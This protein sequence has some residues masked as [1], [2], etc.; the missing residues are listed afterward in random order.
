ML[1]KSVVSFEQSKMAMASS[2]LLLLLLIMILSSSVSAALDGKWSL[3]VQ[4]AGIA[5]MHT[6]VTRFD[7]VILLDR[8]NIGASRINFTNGFCRD[9]PDER[10]LKHDCTAHSVMFDPASNTVRPLTILTDTWCSSGQFLTNGSMV[11]TGG[12]F[13]GLFKVTQNLL[14]SQFQCRDSAL[15]R[16]HKRVR[17]IRFDSQSL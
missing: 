7:T 15:F 6:A 11:Q 13:E 3:L 8:T 17:C 14:L 2:P 9:N 1:L 4:N 5:S 10:V 16:A 12:D